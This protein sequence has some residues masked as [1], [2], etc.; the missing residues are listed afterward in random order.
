VKIGRVG[1][2]VVVALA[3]LARNLLQLQD[4]IWLKK[5]TTTGA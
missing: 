4:R 2:L 3:G 5:K 1:Q